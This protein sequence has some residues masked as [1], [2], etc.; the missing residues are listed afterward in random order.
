M[1]CLHATGTLLAGAIVLVIGFA[2]IAKLLAIDQS[3]EDMAAY[4]IVQLPGPVVGSGMLLLSAFEVLIGAA[5]FY[6]P[7]RRVAQV[8]ALLLLGVLVVGLSVQIRY[9]NP[10]NCG[11]LGLLQRFETLSTDA[12]GALRRGWILTILMAAAM[13]AQVPVTGMEKK[14]DV[15]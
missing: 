8:A 6:S 5:W 15:P 7:A 3:I 1:R 2:G 12:R 13:L 11:C 4:S 14:K 9:S 10:P